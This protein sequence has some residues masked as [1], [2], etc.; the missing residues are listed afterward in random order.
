MYTRY[1]QPR[2]TCENH[3]CCYVNA[4]LDLACSLKLDCTIYSIIQADG[5]TTATVA[6]CLGARHLRCIRLQVATAHSPRLYFSVSGNATSFLFGFLTYVKHPG[7]RFDA[8]GLVWE[9]TLVTLHLLGG[10]P[11]SCWTSERFKVHC[12]TTAPFMSR[13]LP[14]D[15]LTEHAKDH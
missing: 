13:H 15:L 5:D 6:C 14:C 3:R 1:S 12:A 10:R 8:L 4:L 9:G 2:S 7:E 11:A